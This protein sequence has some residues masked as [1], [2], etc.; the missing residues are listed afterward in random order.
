MP[1]G[2]PGQDSSRPRLP[3]LIVSVSA[4]HHKS[5]PGRTFPWTHHGD[6]SAPRAGDVGCFP[7]GVQPMPVRTAPRFDPAMGHLLENSSRACQ[8][9][10]SAENG[11]PAPPLL[12][13]EVLEAVI[14]GVR[15]DVA[16]FPRVWNSGD[17][18]LIPAVYFCPSV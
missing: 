3:V 2:W 17:D 7:C 4:P 8:P 1:A 15:I 18:L 6:R 14:R 5:A 16:V 13:R 12:D 10:R 11:P 9:G